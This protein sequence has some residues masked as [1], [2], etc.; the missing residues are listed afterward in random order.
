MKIYP[1][2]ARWARY[3]IAAIAIYWSWYPYLLSHLLPSWP[4]LLAYLL[5]SNG[6]TFLLHVQITISHFGLPA[7]DTPTVQVDEPFEPFATRNLR[8][9]M[10][11]DCPRWMDWFHGGLQVSLVGIRCY[12]DDN[13]RIVS[14][15]PHSYTLPH[16][17]TK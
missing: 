3:E 5:V 10:D 9:T 1:A 13:L 2:S 6:L 7:D 16:S 11:V 15:Q 17:S 8:T 12:D 14:S 4:T